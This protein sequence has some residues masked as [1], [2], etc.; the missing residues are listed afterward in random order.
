M[1]TNV[2]TA[3][4]QDFEYMHENLFFEKSEGMIIMLI[5]N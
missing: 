5:D 4:M 2:N 3:K 1:I